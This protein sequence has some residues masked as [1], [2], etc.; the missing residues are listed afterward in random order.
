MR[1]RSTGTIPA[2]AV[3]AALRPRGLWRRWLF[4]GVVLLGMAACGSDTSVRSGAPGAVA[5]DR[6][7][8]PPESGPVSLWLSA[9][10]VPPGAEVVAVLR[11]PTGVEVTFGVAAHVDRWDGAAWVAHRN[12]PMCLDFWHCTGKPQA[13]DADFVVPSIGLS[14]VGGI[15][16]V[17]RFTTAGLDLGWYRIRQRA[18]EDIVAT[19]I[20]HVTDDAPAPAP[21]TPTDEP[22]VSLGPVILSPEGG[23]ITAFPIIPASGASQS[24]DD[25][26]VATA[27]LQDPAVIERWDGSRWEKETVVD[28][29]RGEQRGGPDLDRYADLPALPAGAY[30]F[31]RTAEDGYPAHTGRFW[32]VAEPGR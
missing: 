23:R 28:L 14:P 2:S 6:P 1:R 17:E 16:S 30:R 20:L 18:N 31:V 10:E 26:V 5:A 29:H 32:V 13:I 8:F 4:A 22:A 21:L 19:G 15:G 25:V 3:V 9:D 12:L 27:H 7:A 24:S 11:N